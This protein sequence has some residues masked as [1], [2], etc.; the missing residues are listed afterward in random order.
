MNINATVKQWKLVAMIYIFCQAQKTQCF[1]LK[2]N[3]IIEYQVCVCAHSHQCST[4][5]EDHKDDQGF[6]PVVLHNEIAGLPEEPPILTPALRD[7]HITTLV[8]SHTTC[9]MAHI[10][11][12][13]SQS[14]TVSV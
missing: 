6:K 4:T 14:I 11:L 2:H 1:M 7:G 12:L 8:A 9:K 13:F 10:I 5:E 3:I